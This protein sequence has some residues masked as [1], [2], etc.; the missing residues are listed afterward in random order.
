MPEE[1]LLVVIDMQRLFR[2]PESPWATPGFD[3]LAGPITRLVEAF[4]DRTVFT[5]F[6]VPERFEGSWVAYYKRWGEVTRPERRAWA[7][8]ADPYAGLRPRT[9]ER[10]TFGKWG[11]EL[12]A[13]AGPAGTLVLCGVATD[14]CVIA[15]ALPAADAGAFVRVVG[16]ACRGATAEAHE[17]ALA[18]MGGFA[19]QIVVTSVEEEL[20]R[21]AG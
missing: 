9:L 3:E 12:A 10:P 16:D 6:V 13:L 2:D 8:L 20:G 21:L 5:R 14:C 4:G 18:I 15:T 11:P 19:P 17:R 7:E 1:P